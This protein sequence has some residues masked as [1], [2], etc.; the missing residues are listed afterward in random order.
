[1]QLKTYSLFIIIIFVCVVNSQIVKAQDSA[2][3]VTAAAIW[4]PGMA[5]MNE[6]AENCG[7]SELSA[8]GSCLTDIMRKNGASP[9]AIEFAGKMGTVS[10]MNGFK[11][12]G[13]ID[14]AFIYYPLRS[15]GREGC[16]LVNGKPNFLNLNNIGL[17]PV[18]AMELDSEYIELEKEF[19]HLWIF[20]DDMRGTV[21]PYSENLPD[22]VTRI[23]SVY[24]LRNGCSS[25]QLIA[26]A[27]YAFD[28][29]STGTYL[30]CE[31]MDIKTVNNENRNA[32]SSSNPS[33]YFSNP[34]EPV[35]VTAGN[36]FT[37]SLVSNHSQ[38]FKWHLANKLDTNLVSLVG[39][40]FTKPYETLPNAP[41]KELWFFKAKSKGTTVIQL[42]YIPSWSSGAKSYKTYSFTVNIN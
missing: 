33:E 25:C 26:F 14:A 24:S 21:Y 32:I 23:V 34:D 13:M 6:I 9:Q 7:R 39:T 22:K 30:G 15:L 27:E 38:G 8:T 19:P 1:M 3:T 2:Y 36:N 5:I 12:L 11:E 10:Y 40:D 4:N 18:Q 41:G 28:F 35:N 20:S 17:L 16:M 29:D 31:F 42:M 37:I